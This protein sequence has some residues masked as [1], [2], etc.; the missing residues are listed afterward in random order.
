M[1]AVPETALRK[2]IGYH[3]I[4]LGGFATLAAALLMMG[5]LA[6][7][8]SI[9]QRQQEDLLASL[10]QVIPASLYDEGLLDHNLAFTDGQGTAHTIYRAVRNGQVTAVA[11]QV[12]G[13]GYAGDIALLMGVDGSGR[14]LGVRVLAHAETPGLGDKIEPEKSHWIDAFVGRSLGDPSEDRWGVR[15]D[16]GAFDQFTGATITPRGVV[17]AIKDGL[18][19]FR[20]HKGELLARLPSITVSDPKGD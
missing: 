9:L 8:D 16:G 3:A 13:N 11:Y 1:S 2:R 17:A 10:N 6:T 18:L 14:L 4:L 7:R 15:K 12:I 5:N 20:E 19:F